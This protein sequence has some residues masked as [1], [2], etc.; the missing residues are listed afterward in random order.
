M[1]SR[2]RRRLER[3][4]PHRVFVYWGG[5]GAAIAHHWLHKNMPGQFR[6]NRGMN[7]LEFRFARAQDL[8]WFQLA[9]PRPTKVNT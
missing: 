9:W 2:Q 6:A 5:N 8:T 4:Y 3:A 7:G 1:N